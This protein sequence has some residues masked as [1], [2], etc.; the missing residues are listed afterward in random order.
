MDIDIYCVY[1]YIYIYM[2]VWTHTCSSPPVRMQCGLWQTC[3]TK[4]HSSAVGVGDSPTLCL[5][6]L[7][8]RSLCWSS[9]VW[10]ARGEGWCALTEWR[11]GGESGSLAGC[12]SSSRIPMTTD[13]KHHI[14][15]KPLRMR[16]L[17]WWRP[18]KISPHTMFNICV[19]YKN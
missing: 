18:V 7:K 19:L 2:S 8:S 16:M 5:C 1:I 12:E 13:A 6:N 11:N 17:G 3:R 9:D 4:R 15:T 14:V 10:L